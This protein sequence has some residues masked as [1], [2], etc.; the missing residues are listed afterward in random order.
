MKEFDVTLNGRIIGEGYIL[1]CKVRAVKTTLDEDP[2]A[3][4]A[5]SDYRV[6]NSDETDRLP[7]GEYE[8][9]VNGQRILLRR[10]AWRFHG[11]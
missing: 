8:L 1:E 4:P 2:Y 7:D 9:L 10:Q 11:L 5:F 3:P 6:W